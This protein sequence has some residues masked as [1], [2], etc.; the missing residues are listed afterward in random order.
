MCTSVVLYVGVIMGNEIYDSLLSFT[1]T[2]RAAEYTYPNIRYY[3]VKVILNMFWT[4][5]W[6]F[7]KDREKLKEE[8]NMIVLF[9]DS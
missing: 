7:K 8:G 3:N 9:A 6:Y 4:M 2:D 1:E 5:S